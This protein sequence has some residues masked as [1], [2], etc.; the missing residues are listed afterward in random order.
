MKIPIPSD[1]EER[2]REIGGNRGAKRYRELHAYVA[3]QTD[4]PIID[5]ERN[6]DG[7][8]YAIVGDS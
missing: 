3:E 1:V 2:A 8:L 4:K 5:W 6:Q 7:D